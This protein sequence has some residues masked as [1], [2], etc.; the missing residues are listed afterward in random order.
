M[1]SHKYYCLIL[2]LLILLVERSQGQNV[3]NVYVIDQEL[4]KNGVSLL[5]YTR[6]FE[7][8]VSL[9]I[10]DLVSQ[11]D[12]YLL[13][14]HSTSQKL[15]SESNY[16]GKISVTNQAKEI[17]DIVIQI[18][19]NNFANFYCYRGREFIKASVSGELVE[20]SQKDLA[21]GRKESICG[22]QIAPKDT[23]S[24][25]FRLHN[26]THF[27]PEVTP[28]LYEKDQW[29]INASKRVLIDGLYQ[30]F[31][32]FL[33]C[34][35][36][37]FYIK[38][39]DKTYLYFSSY[40]F[41]FAI[42][43]S[44]FKGLI[45]QFVLPDVPF[46]NIYLWLVSGL[47]PI[48]YL[49][50]LR[51]FIHTKNLIP[52]WDDWIKKLVWFDLVI[53]TISAIVFHITFNRP[54][55]VMLI[56][57]TV[58]L[59]LILGFGLLYV[60]FRTK[61][62]LANYFIVGSLL[63]VIAA[64]LGII[65]YDHFE[66]Q[67]AVYY[68]MGGSAVELTIFSLGLAKRVEILRKQKK[69]ADAELIAQLRKNEQLQEEV[70]AALAKT[71]DEQG[72]ELVYK[73]EE[74][75]KAVDKLKAIN[76]ELQSFAYTVAHDLKAPLRA[77]S[78]LSSF[79]GEDEKYPLKEE[80]QNSLALLK[81]QVKKMNQLIKGVL[82]YSTAA[83]MVQR[84]QPIDLNIL[85]GEIAKVS[86]AFSKIKI[87]YDDLPVIHGD[88]VKIHQV[89]QN[90]ISNAVKFTD[91]V[92]GVIQIGAEDRPDRW[93]LWVKDNGKGIDRKHFER[94]FIIFK[95]IAAHG[96]PEGTGIGLTIVKKIVELHG[97]EVWIESELGQGSTFYFSIVKNI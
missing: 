27:P 85:V 63:L 89:F 38:I 55:A 88:E 23:M 7:D 75:N 4:P 70:K 16:W 87:E 6:I 62:T 92:D 44:W 58:L 48:F 71:I 72:D 24:I 67:N 39:K 33:V 57:N 96:Q 52:K 19:E 65:A 28:T 29:S 36:L 54:L 45:H 73:N 76:G 42:Y 14:L 46:F 66:Y 22:V 10:D 50:F 59:N 32:W 20:G 1:M 15:N 60:L 90:L 97:G 3:N 81:S 78:Y 61:N 94:I 41:C 9:K 34:Y 83:S 5:E 31:L 25:Y 51:Q 93:V 30:G 47:I 64:V 77:I 8:T 79:I 84:V 82:K 17:A 35:S 80:D 2:G 56:N 68:I 40:V 95:T 12:Q 69:K 11:S 13:P 91:P 21:I 53:F 26:V 49:L 37:A 74:L 86:T 43:F 18:G